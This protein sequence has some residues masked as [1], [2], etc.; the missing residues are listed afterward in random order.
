VPHVADVG[1]P[2][3]VGVVVPEPVIRMSAQSRKIS[4]RTGEVPQRDNQFVAYKP[5]SATLHVS[6]HELAVW[7]S[8]QADEQWDVNVLQ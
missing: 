4:F 8:L 6:T 2:V 5:H 3:G 1:V 7:Y